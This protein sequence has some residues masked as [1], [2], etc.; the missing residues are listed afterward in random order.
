M[1]NFYSKET[2]DAK[3]E[4]IHETTKRIEAQTIKTNG[5]VTENRKLIDD[6]NTDV[7]KWKNIVVG[8][9]VVAGIMGAPNVFILAKTL[10]GL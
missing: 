5:R 9:A 8:G 3:L 4:V 10:F 6:L 2:I 1:D 7:N